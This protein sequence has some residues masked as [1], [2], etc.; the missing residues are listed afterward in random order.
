[1]ADGARRERVRVGRKTS[2]SHGEA[3]GTNGTVVTRCASSA[4]GD[5]VVPPP[6]GGSRWAQAMTGKAATT[7]IIRIDLMAHLVHAETRTVS[8][9]VVGFALNAARRQGR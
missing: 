3:R 1:M 2:A 8:R 7:T 9:K 5:H 4:S 6:S